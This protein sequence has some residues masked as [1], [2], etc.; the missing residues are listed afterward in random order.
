MVLTKTSM[1]TDMLIITDYRILLLLKW[2]QQLIHIFFY[3][4]THTEKY[5]IHFYCVACFVVN[6]FLCCWWMTQEIWL[7]LVNMFLTFRLYTICCLNTLTAVWWKKARTQQR[8]ISGQNMN[9][10][11]QIKNRKAGQFD[12]SARHHY[13][14]FSYKGAEWLD[15][16]YR[17]FGKK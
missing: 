11:H 16:M 7:L 17:M 6:S 9:V 12:A 10:W 2:R 15:D 14:A 4:S 13:I 3:W 5:T 1:K 8:A